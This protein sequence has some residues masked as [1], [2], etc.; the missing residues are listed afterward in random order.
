MRQNRLPDDLDFDRE[1]IE[2]TQLSQTNENFG[3]SQNQDLTQNSNSSPTKIT[4]DEPNIANEEQKQVII[5]G[6]FFLFYK[7]I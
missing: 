4:P 2:E 6:Y 5:E 1:K 7:T 3:S